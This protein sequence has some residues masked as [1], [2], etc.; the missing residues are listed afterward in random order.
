[1]GALCYRYHCLHTIQVLRYF[2]ACGPAGRP[3]LGPFRFVLWISEGRWV[4]GYG[5]GTEESGFTNMDD[6][7]QG[8]LAALKPMRFDK[9][10]Q[11]GYEVMNLGSAEPI[12]LNDAI[13][14]VEGSAGVKADI[15]CNPRHPVDV[16]AT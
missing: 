11:S 8:T 14:L 7:A 6:I 2:T 12:A 13:W 5:D 16:L 1:M 10:Q 15:E 4:I 3:H 9:P